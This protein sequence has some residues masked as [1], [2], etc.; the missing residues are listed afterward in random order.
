MSASQRQRLSRGFHRLGLS[1][2]AILLL[3][4]GCA[5]IAG[6]S[7]ADLLFTLAISLVVYCVIRAMSGPLLFPALASRSNEVSG[8]R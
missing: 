7:G 2:A 4:V 3:V 5:F 6:A 8:H 1:L